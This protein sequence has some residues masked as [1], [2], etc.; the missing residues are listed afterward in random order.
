VFA[1][2]RADRFH[3]HDTPVSESVTVKKIVFTEERARQE[4]D[5]L[6]G[7][8]SSDDEVEYFWQVTRLERRARHEE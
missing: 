6:N 3:S 1:I 8:R 2:L 4:V 7:L 5:R